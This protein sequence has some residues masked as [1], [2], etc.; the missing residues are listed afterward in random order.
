M[1][2]K[3]DPETD[4]SPRNDVA[5]LTVQ[6]VQVVSCTESI[7]LNAEFYRDI[8]LFGGHLLLI[9][10]FNRMWVV[11]YAGA[12]LPAWHD[13][14]RTKTNG[15]G[16]ISANTCFKIV[17][18]VFAIVIA[19]V[20]HGFVRYCCFCRSTASPRN[21]DPGIQENFA[22]TN[23]VLWTCRKF[24]SRYIPSSLAIMA[25][26][27]LN[28]QAP[29]LGS[30]FGASTGASLSVLLPLLI[31]GK[32]VNHNLDRTGR[33]VPNSRYLQAVG[34][35][36][37]GM[38]WVPLFYQPQQDGKPSSNTWTFQEELPGFLFLSIT[39][40][41]LAFAWQWEGRIFRHHQENSSERLRHSN[42][43]VTVRHMLLGLATVSL[44]LRLFIVLLNGQMG[45][46]REFLSER[47]V[48]LP[49]T[50]A[51]FNHV[52]FTLVELSM[53]Q[54]L[55]PVA[56]GMVYVL[57]AWYPTVGKYTPS[58]MIGG[59]L[60]HPGWA[61][62]WLWIFVSEFIRYKNTYIQPIDPETAL[63]GYR[64]QNLQQQEDEDV[65]EA[66]MVQLTND[67]SDAAVIATV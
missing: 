55:G 15:Y 23:S 61:A 57:L 30:S 50:A 40:F 14:Q 65:E 32:A 44:S 20:L 2:N 64:F 28:Q 43:V 62:V 47:H 5:V 11:A 31:M 51:A 67:D 66:E 26:T 21:D 54:R 49:S 39:L 29:R 36:I 34:L 6:G 4:A 60:W 42:E 46:F 41:F 7:F 25:F 19:L 18:D 33:P 16:M 8:L 35:T 38:M 45:E 9:Y 3:K 52:L 63:Q 10:I 37:L 1:N 27:W 56:Y 22:M 12:Y 59:G 53:I 13:F 24:L 17:R 58:T 48:F